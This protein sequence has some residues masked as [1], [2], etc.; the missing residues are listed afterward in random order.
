M[1]PG[2]VEDRSMQTL[3]GIE[4]LVVDEGTLTLGTDREE[5]I[6]LRQRFIRNPEIPD[7]SPVIFQERSGVRFDI[8]N[9]FFGCGPTAGV[10]AADRGKEDP[11][12]L[13]LPDPRE[14]EHGLKQ[15][16]FPDLFRMELGE[17]HA[18]GAAQ[19]VGHNIRGLSGGGEVP[20]KGGGVFRM[21]RENISGRGHSASYM[22]ASVI[23]DD[24]E[25]LGQ[26]LSRVFI[27]V[28][29]R[30]APVDEQKKGALAGFPHIQRGSVKAFEMRFGIIH[31]NF[32]Q[33]DVG[34]G[35]TGICSIIPDL[36]TGRK[37]NGE[38][39][40]SEMTIEPEADDPGLQV[41]SLQDE[42]DPCYIGITGISLLRFSINRKEC[43]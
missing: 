5:D 6:D 3:C 10:L 38:F 18:D 7:E 36:C 20:D 11:K 35:Q 34:S 9:L 12:V 17:F 40:E 30:C 31:G 13:L 4:G 19:A 21:G 39:R 41:F 27:E 32:L 23:G 28:G 15:E 42:R 24:M 29:I 1:E 37:E 2:V 14:L 8:G 25:G 33:W 16:Q 43:L 22:A 26:D